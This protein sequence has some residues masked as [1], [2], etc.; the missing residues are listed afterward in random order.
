MSLT[1]STMVASMSTVNTFMRTLERSESSTGKRIA[2]AINSSAI[3]SSKKPRNAND[4]RGQ[5]DDDD[6]GSE[7]RGRRYRQERGGQRD[8]YYQGGRGDGDRE[9]RYK[10]RGHGYL[11]K[12][13][14]K[15]RYQKNYHRDSKGGYKDHRD[16]KGGDKGGHYAKKSHHDNK[17]RGRRS[18]RDTRGASHYADEGMSCSPCRS[19]KRSPSPDESSRESSRRTSRSPSTHSRQTSSSDDRDHAYATNEAA[20]RRERFHIEDNSLFADQGSRKS[21]RSYSM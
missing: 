7:R 10:G 4:R 20:A 16:S 6:R 15:G 8:R 21:D 19:P 18:E 13:P 5:D 1:S 11:S 12:R 2:E 9:R 14:S 17:E 3:A